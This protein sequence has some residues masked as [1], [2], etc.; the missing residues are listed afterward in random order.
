MVPQLA[1]QAKELSVLV[2]LKLPKKKPYVTIMLPFS[3]A[4][5]TSI[6]KILRDC[7]DQACVAKPKLAKHAVSCSIVMVAG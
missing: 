7:D 5:M 6:S 3:K 2:N 1:K 4:E